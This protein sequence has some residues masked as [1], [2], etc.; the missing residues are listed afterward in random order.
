MTNIDDSSKLFGV[1]ISIDEAPNPYDG[2]EAVSGCEDSDPEI[3]AIGE[4]TRRQQKIVMA[5]TC[6][7]ADK[8]DGE[9][10][11]RE[12]VDKIRDEF[13]AR[14]IDP[15]D[16]V[17]FLSDRGQ[18][19]HQTLLSNIGSGDRM[20]LQQL[21]S[22]SPEITAGRRRNRENL[23][24]MDQKQIDF[25]LDLIDCPE[26]GAV[27]EL[28]AG[29]NQDRITSLK[30]HAESR[31]GRLICHDLVPELAHSVGKRVGGVPYL[32]LPNTPEFMSPVFERF[33]RQKVVS[34]DNGLS[35][36]AYGQIIDLGKVFGGIGTERAVI[37]QSMGIAPQTNMLPQK[38]RPGNQDFYNYVVDE[39]RHAWNGVTSKLTSQKDADALPYF[40]AKKAEYAIY[41]I[42]MEIARTLLQ[43]TAREKAG[44]NASKTYYVEHEEDIDTPK[45]ME[46]TASFISPILLEMVMNGGINQI[47]LVPFS[48]HFGKSDDVPDGKTRLV[49]G[50]YE[51]VLAKDSK[52]LTSPKDDSAKRIIEIDPDEILTPLEYRTC[53]FSS[54]YASMADRAMASGRRPP[55]SSPEEVPD[56]VRKLIDHFGGFLATKLMFNIW[57]TRIKHPIFEAADSQGIGNKMHEAFVDPYAY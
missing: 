17:Y 48:A 9:R 44:L 6:V 32:I 7:V 50:R 30:A 56:S 11:S 28:M 23:Q 29:E 43:N 54:M 21:G 25:S 13:T 26:N 35:R 20:T 31:G 27:I 4:E 38:I 18:N 2:L 8:L 51:I 10:L 24:G 22:C 15:N 41:M 42:A 3:A 40:L 55:Y 33:K 19:L 1:P 36:M 53:D 47:S 37:G 5:L 52:N 34:M 16:L 49:T 46:I 12:D 57:G 45:A 39:I 14:G